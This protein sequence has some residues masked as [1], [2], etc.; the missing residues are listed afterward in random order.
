M[1]QSPKSNRKVVE[2]N[3][4]VVTITWATVTIN[5]F[6]VSHNFVLDIRNIV[7]NTILRIKMFGVS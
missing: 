3:T 2:Y 5:E 4:P 7:Q 6:K 1:L